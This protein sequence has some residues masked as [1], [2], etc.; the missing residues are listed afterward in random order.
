MATAIPPKAADVAI[1]R[2]ERQRF[3]RSGRAGV[4]PAA[5]AGWWGP[6]LNEICVAAWDNFQKNIG[7]ESKEKLIFRNRVY[8]E[9][10]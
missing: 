6:D 5:S 2:L 8:V 3:R 9:E 7:K 1:K 10:G 4:S